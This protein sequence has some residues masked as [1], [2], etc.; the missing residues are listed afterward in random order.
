M[1]K[2]VFLNDTR[3]ETNPGCHATVDKLLAIIDKHLSISEITIF[4]LGTAYEEFQEMNSINKRTKWFLKYPFKL[5]NFLERVVLSNYFGSYNSWKWISSN[6]IPDK[7]CSKIDESD[8]VIINM[9]GTIHHNRTGGLA[10]LGLAKYA[11]EQGKK[12]ALVNGSYQ[13][14]DGRV[15][16]T[17]FKQVDFVSVREVKSFDYLKAHGVKVHLIPDFAFLANIC[18]QS[19]FKLPSLK[20]KSSSKRCLYTTGVRALDNHFD[21]LNF[22]KD[23]KQQ[24]LILKKKGFEIYFLQIEEKE[25][26]LAQKLREIDVFV[27]SYKD[28][29]TYK[30]I[31][32][33]LKNFD[34]IV[35]GRYHVGIFGLMVNKPT[36][37]LKS[38]TYK[39]EGLL[40][41]F[42][43]KNLLVEQSDD[44][45]KKIEVLSP[46]QIRLPTNQQYSTFV[47]FLR[48]L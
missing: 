39:I 3:I 25:E 19:D 46:A 23:I 24:V 7:V 13:S 32:T 40:Q 41:M 27:I 16:R 18:E 14:M 37:F 8:I 15:T 26:H 35:T 21:S 43:L 38:N 4:P 34:L 44:L 36:L 31:G 30:N 5:K 9:E 28:N 48:N 1:T 22:F 29:I 45:S 20:M 2:V 12:V 6:R 10:L 42:E 33:L 17:V 11:K 47:N